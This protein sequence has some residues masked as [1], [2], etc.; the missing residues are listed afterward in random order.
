VNIVKRRMQTEEQRFQFGDS[1]IPVPEKTRPAGP[2]AA[3]RGICP[4]PTEGSGVASP[5]NRASASLSYAA[6][7]CLRTPLWPFRQH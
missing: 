1:L 7:G 6:V 2:C 4:R 3:G 5:R